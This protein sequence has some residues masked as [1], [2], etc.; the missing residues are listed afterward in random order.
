MFL[1]AASLG[2]NGATSARR[3]P[4]F[5]TGDTHTAS[6]SPRKAVLILTKIQKEKEK[7]QKNRL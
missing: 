6:P 7:I 5:K 1:A 3:A 4:V 2:E